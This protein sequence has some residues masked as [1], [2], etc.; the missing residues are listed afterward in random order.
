MCIICKFY[1]S[2]GKLNVDEYKN[3]P[4]VRQLDYEQIEAV[5]AKDPQQKDM[6]SN[7]DSASRSRSLITT[8]S[9][10][11]GSISLNSQ[12][13]NLDLSDV[14]INVGNVSKYLKSAASGDCCPEKIE[15]SQYDQDLITHKW[16]VYIRSPNCKN[17]ENYIKKVIFYL[18]PSYKPYDIVQV[19]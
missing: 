3:H 10:T 2:E 4:I 15:A 13:P 9:Q 12:L 7:D 8:D 19:K 18:H 14:R 17:L 11:P 5:F 1:S 16:M 6:T